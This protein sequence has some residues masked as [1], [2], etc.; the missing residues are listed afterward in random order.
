[1]QIQINKNKLKTKILL[2]KQ[3]SFV[4]LCPSALG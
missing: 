2:A 3:T 1:M 4:A